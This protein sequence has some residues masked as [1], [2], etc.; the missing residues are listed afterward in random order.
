MQLLSL[1]VLEP[2]RHTWRAHVPQ[3]KISQDATK[4]R[5]NH[6]NTQK[7]KKSGL[8]RGT[9]SLSRNLRAPAVVHGQRSTGPSLNHLMGAK[10]ASLKEVH[11][12]AKMETVATVLSTSETSLIG[13]GPS[14]NARFSSFRWFS[15]IFHIVSLEKR[16]FYV[17]LW[18]FWIKLY[19]RFSKWNVMFQMSHID[20]SSS[21]SKWRA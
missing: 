15:L 12:G 6:I 17:N 13:W 14:M 21:H 9:Q 19:H 11:C 2:V 7:K 4:T 20:F 16:G 3:L 5:Y 8:T 18:F 10:E 1:C